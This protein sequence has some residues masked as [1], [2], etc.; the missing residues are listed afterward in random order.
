MAAGALIMA[1][2]RAKTDRET[3]YHGPDGLYLDRCIPQYLLQK[4]GDVNPLRLRSGQ[5]VLDNAWA[6]QAYEQ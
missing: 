2:T 3:W 1:N 5:I 4:A 6:K